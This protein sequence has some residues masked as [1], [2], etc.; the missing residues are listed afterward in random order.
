MC[1]LSV[2]LRENLHFTAC[3]VNFRFLVL[4]RVY[5]LNAGV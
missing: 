5:T 2:R 4:L 1:T 3:G